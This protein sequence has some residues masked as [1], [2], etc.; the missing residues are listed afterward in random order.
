MTKGRKARSRMR[1]GKVRRKR[2]TMRKGVTRRKATR[3]RA[4]RRAPTREVQLGP[5]LRKA[6]G[7]SSED[8]WCGVENR[9]VVGIRSG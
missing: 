2:V 1:R 5:K 7:M 6:P 9:G 8:G 4:A 3:K